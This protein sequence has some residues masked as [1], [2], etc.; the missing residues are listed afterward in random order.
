MTGNAQAPLPD[1][2]STV[3]L[4]EPGG[5]AS[6]ARLQS[7][8]PGGYTVVLPVD[9]AITASPEP[10]WNFT[11]SWPMPG[12]AAVVPV[13]I[14]DRTDSAQICIWR[15]AATG[16]VEVEIRRMERRVPV[17]G[18]VSITVYPE[19]GPRALL[20]T[21]SDPK[22]L[23][24]S[25]IDISPSAVQC[26]V[27]TS[28]DAAVIHSDTVATC[29]FDLDGEHLSL[30]ATVLGAWSTADSQR[31]RVVLIFDAGQPALADVV[32][33]IGSVDD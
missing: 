22:P 28:Q 26:V 4:R 15:L 27:D 19:L 5:R 2:G 10:E 18:E 25:L 20:A 30:R 1:V 9:A 16:P 33:Y 32:D 6:L 31:L 3:E 29:E 8:D 13:T 17:E 14:T 12:G 23:T 11:L 21:A 24:G 7:I